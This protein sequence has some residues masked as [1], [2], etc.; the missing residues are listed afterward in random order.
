MNPFDKIEDPR[1]RLLVEALTLGYFALGMPAPAYAQVFGSRPTKLPPEQSIYKLAGAVRVN[2]TSA[3]MK[4]R[5]RPGDTVETGADGE[6][7][8]VVGDQA[9]LLR[10]NSR[11][12]IE[13][14][15]GINV[16]RA[17][18]LRLA[19]GKI[20]SVSRNQP[21]QVTTGTATMGIRGTGWYAEADPEQTYFCT[22]YGQ[23]E[24][25]ANSDPNARETIT[26]KHHDRPVYILAKAGGGNL[27]RNAP[28]INHTD[29][30]LSLLET[31]VGRTPPFVFAKDDYKGPRRDY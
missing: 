18:G 17:S 25:T 23:T 10:A 30:E 2:N 13:G 5:I 1:R 31:L 7:S 11:L 14:G 26:A 15:T 16:T 21:M 20:L 12:V 9:M 3:D 6:I 24:V 19:I 22:C 8:F 29:Q 27:I 28:F 4:T